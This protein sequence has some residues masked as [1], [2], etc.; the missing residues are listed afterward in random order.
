MSVTLSNI[1]DKI[2][3]LNNRNSF[4]S[5]FEIRDYEIP[6]QSKTE[7]VYYKYCKYAQG[8]SKYS[9]NVL[10]LGELGRYPI[11]IKSV[12]LGILYWWR[13]E[14][15]TENPLLN[16]AYNT[17]KEE[18]H[19]WLQNIHFLYK[20]GMGDIW[21]SP[22]SWDK[23]HLKSRVTSCLQNMF[24][25]KYYECMNDMNNVDKCKITNICKNS[26]YSENKYLSGI[27]SPQIRRIFTKLRIDINSTWD[28]KVRSFRYKKGPTTG[29]TSHNSYNSLYL[30]LTPISSH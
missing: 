9:S 8:I 18:N 1:M 3:V 28:S 20:I 16:S 24:I 5:T 17:M 29:C 19:E 27:E 2:I 10:T 6:K 25:Q 23:E 30:Q 22:R 4:T 11:L 13:L 12:V 14:M 15:E 21:Q 26:M 7:T